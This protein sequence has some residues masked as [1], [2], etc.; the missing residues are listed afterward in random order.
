MLGRYYE[1]EDT[2]ASVTVAAQMLALT[3]PADMSVQIVEASLTTD[4]D[5]SEQIQGALDRGVGTAAG[6]AVVVALPL[7]FGDV[8]TSVVELSASGAAITGATQQDELFGAEFGP[9]PVGWHYK[10]IDGQGKIYSPAQII[11]IRNLGTIST[12]TVRV[13]CVFKEIG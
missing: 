1:V 5:A 6:G 8:A 9:T 10:P 11:L 4:L 3:V 13:R 7:L 12:T 2:I